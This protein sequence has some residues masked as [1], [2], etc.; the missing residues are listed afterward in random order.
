MPAPS[1][2]IAHATPLFLLHQWLVAIRTSAALVL[3]LLACLAVAG[4]ARAQPLQ[5]DAD[6]SILERSFNG[7]LQAFHDKTGQL[8]REQVASPAYEQ[9]FKTL[10]GA[11]NG[12]YAKGAWWMRLQIQAS[13]AQV[14]HPLE[15]G[16]WLRLNAP[17]ADYIDVWWPDVKGGASDGFTHRALGG[18]R[19]GS[20]RELSWSIPAVR[21]PDLTDTEPRWV[22]VRLAGDRTLS[23]AGGV[24][25]LREQA[26][27]QQELDYVDAAVTGMVLLMAV[28]SLMMGIALPD[29]RFT[30][31]AG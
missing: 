28:V 26:V 15:G 5:L 6:L 2:P 23:L 20:K 19:A 27:V 16:W 7:R 12:G 25:P 21:L 18:M 31:Y 29:R 14:A 3:F 9:Q 30:W 13:P 4:P 24:S 10:E 1:T 17:C 11:F 8:T 22:W